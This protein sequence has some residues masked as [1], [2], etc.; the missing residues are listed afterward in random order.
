MLMGGVGGALL[1]LLGFLAFREPAQELGYLYTDLDPA[2]AQSITEKLKADN[3]PFQLSADGTGVMAP[4]DRL[5]ELR[6]SLAGEQMGGKI[7][8]EVLDQ[9]EP[10]GVSSSRAKLNETRAVEG[11]LVKSIESLEAVQKARVHI[12]MPERPM[13]AAEGRK[14]SAAVTVKT[15]G[16][17][18][19][20][21]IQSIRYLVSSSVPELSPESVSIVDQSGALLARAGEA[22]GA[23]SSEIEERQAAMEARMRDQIEALVEPIVGEGKVRVEVA[24]L[25]ERDQSREEANVYDPDKQVV[26]HQITVES[27]DESQENDAGAEGATVATQLPENQGQAGG[28]GGDTRQS[29][30]NESSE[31]TTYDNSATHTVTVRAPGKVNRLTVAVLVDGGPRGVPAAQITRLTRL[32]ENAVGF[33]AERG[34]SVAVESMAFAAPDDLGEADGMLSKLP[35]DQ[36]FSVLKVL[37]LAAVILFGARMLRDRRRGDAPAGAAG[38]AMALTGPDGLPALPGAVNGEGQSLEELEAIRSAQSEL[39]MLDQEIALAQVD[40]RIKLSA[41]KRIGDAVKASPGE[42]ASVVRQWMNA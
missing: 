4:Q 17:L 25:L 19:N 6:M 42:S 23:D 9:E 35:W 39:A 16:H 30:K 2:A 12:V 22:G 8:Y 21:S 10:F 7:G 14:A 36:I 33:D 24:A 20:Q 27:G 40:G 29:R 31:D 41:L 1:L 3:I 13:F 34:D 15:R 18:P 5:A 28:A 26:K 11:E 38:T 32:V 37:I